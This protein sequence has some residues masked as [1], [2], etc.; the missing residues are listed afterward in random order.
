MTYWES[1]DGGYILYLKG[2]V[3]PIAKLVEDLEDE[4]DEGRSWIYSIFIGEVPTEY[5]TYEYDD[6]TID[7]LKKYVVRQTIRLA[8]GEK[9]WHEELIKKLRNM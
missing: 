1:V 3:C 4:I 7:D 8:Q 2:Y 6:I 9:Y 5:K